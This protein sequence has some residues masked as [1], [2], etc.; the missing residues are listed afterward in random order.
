MKHAPAQIARGLGHIVDIPFAQPALHLLSVPTVMVN[1]QTRIGPSK[2]AFGNGDGP[3]GE[4]ALQVGGRP[5]DPMRGSGG[6]SFFPA[7]GSARKTIRRL[8]VTD[9]IDLHL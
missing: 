6:F 7:G 2:T 9:F 4:P 5:Q 3:F 8:G 1:R